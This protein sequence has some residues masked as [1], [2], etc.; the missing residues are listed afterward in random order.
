MCI[1][2]RDSSLALALPGLL[3]AILFLGIV[4]HRVV[5]VARALAAVSY[6]HLTLPTSD[7]V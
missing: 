4:V 1:R 2:D 5:A 3:A 7:L 6:T